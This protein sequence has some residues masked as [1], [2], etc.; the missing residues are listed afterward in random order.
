MKII[1]GNQCVALNVKSSYTMNNCVYV[2]FKK[3]Y[4]DW[5]NKNKLKIIYEV[6]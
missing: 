3:L 5:L 4:E 2:L 6:C 1:V